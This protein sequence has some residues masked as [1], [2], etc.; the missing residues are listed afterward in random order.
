MQRVELGYKML[1]DIEGKLNGYFKAST[2][3]NHSLGQ[4]S[5]QIPPVPETKEFSEFNYKPL[6][7]K[8]SRSRNDNNRSINVLDSAC[9]IG[10]ISSVKHAQN[11]KTTSRAFD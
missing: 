10:P 1:S 5:L 9:L 4:S 8:R 7:R 11:P 6:S 3:N 2:G